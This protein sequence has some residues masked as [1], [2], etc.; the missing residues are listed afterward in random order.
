M[1][2]SLNLHKALISWGMKYR[3]HHNIRQSIVGAVEA[4][5][6]FVGKITPWE[7]FS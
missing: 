6:Q 3:I 7:A 1:D 4:F 5:I 2:S